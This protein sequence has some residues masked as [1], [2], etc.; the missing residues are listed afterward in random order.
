MARLLL[1]NKEKSRHLESKTENRWRVDGQR[2]SRT[3]SVLHRA[4]N[5]SQLHH[6]SRMRVND[7]L[8]S[9]GFADIFSSCCKSASS[10]SIHPST[11]D[12]LIDSPYIPSLAGK[13]N[14]FPS[15]RRRPSQNETLLVFATLH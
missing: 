5:S 3:T 9:A 8:S 14:P 2:V 13:P 10:T 1:E 12:L 11:A 6:S 4:S 7:S 15:K